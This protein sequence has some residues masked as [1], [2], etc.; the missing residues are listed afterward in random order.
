MDG[1]VSTTKGGAF[2]VKEDPYKSNGHHG[3]VPPTGRGKEQ[4]GNRLERRTS[5]KRGRCKDND[6]NILD[7]EVFVWVRGCLGATLW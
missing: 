3:A 5:K 1:K 6:K 4:G 2:S 7:L